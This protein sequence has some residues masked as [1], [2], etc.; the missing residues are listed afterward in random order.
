MGGFSALHWLIVAALLGYLWLL[1]KI[2][3]PSPIA[4]PVKDSKPWL[5]AQTVIAWVCVVLFGF[6]TLAMVAGNANRQQRPRNPNPGD[7]IGSAGYLVGML[8]GDLVVPLLFALSVR[9][10]RTVMRKWKALKVLPPVEAATVG[11]V[12]K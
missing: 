12:Q 3:K 8:V 10:T 11:P 7:A 2:A 4:T 1:V 9:W 5:R 6:L